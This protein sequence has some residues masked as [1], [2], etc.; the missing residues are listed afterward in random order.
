[1]KR[2]YIFTFFVLLSL[3]S[4]AQIVAPVN[5]NFSEIKEQK[6]SQFEL[7]FVSFEGSENILEYGS[8]PTYYYET[9]VPNEYF[10]CEIEINELFASK[11][12]EA[13][14]NLLSDNDLISDDYQ[15]IIKYSGLSAQ[16]YVLP[17]KWDSNH[18]QIIKLDSFELKID[19]V[20]QEKRHLNSNRTNNYTEES[21]LSSGTWIKMGIANSGVHRLSFTDLES[22]GVNPSQI[23]VNKIGIFGNYN[24]VLPE[25]NL[26]PSIDDLQE[27]S[28]FIS[29]IEDGKFD[30][31]DYILFYAQA[32]T[33]WTYNPFEGRFFHNNNIYSDTTYYFFTP[34]KG[35]AKSITD[36]DGLSLQPT[37]FVTT[38]IDYAVH[39]KESENLMSTGKEWYG[40]V[41]SSDTLEREFSFTFPNLVVDEPIYINFELVGRAFSNSFYDLIIDNTTVSDSNKIRFITTSLG[42]YARKS[43]NKTTFMANGDNLNFKLKYY[44]DD[45]N[46]LAWL[47]FIE[48]SAE[49]NLIFDNGQMIYR[50]LQTAASGNITQ[51]EI[52]TL[53]SNSLIWD[54][55]DIH[56][57]QN[58]SYSISENTIKYTIPTDSLKTFVVFDDSDYYSPISYKEIQNQNL[59]NINDVNFIIIR[60][61]MFEEEAEELANIHRN[62]D[63]LTT[64]CV[65]PEQIYNEFSS[66]S[67]DISAIRNFMRMLY[68][69]GAF[70]NQRAYLLLFGDASFDYKNRIHENTNIVPTYEALESLRATGSFVT[71]DYYGLLDINEGVSVSGDIDIGIGRFPISTK[72]EAISAVDK[73]S[74]YIHKDVDVMRDWRTN[75]C[76]IADDEDNNLHFNQAQGL[77]KIAD[78]LNSGIRISKVYLDAYQRTNIPG[79]HRYPDAAANISKQVEDGALIINYTGHG[80][81]LGWSEETVLDV[82][83]INGFDNINN[84][85]LIITATCE[86]SRFDDPE[87]T[88]AGEYFFLNKKGGAIGLLTTTRL[89]YAHANYIVNRRIYNN[90]LITENGD[91]PRLGDL[92]RLSKIPSNTNYLNFVLLGDPALTLAYPEHNIIT[93]TNIN[94]AVNVSDTIH[95]LSIVNVAGEI[96][97]S[98]N[99]IISNF[100]GYVYPKVIDKATI[101]T[102]LGNAGSSFPAEFKLFDRLLYDGKILVKNGKFEFEFAVPKDI[103][104][105][106]GFGKIQYYAIDTINFVDAWGGF[107]DMYIGGIDEDAIVNDIGP[108]IELYLNKTSFTSGDIVTNNPVL[109][110]YVSDDNGINSTGNG[111]GRNMVLVIDND[112]SNSIIV[113][114]YYSMDVNSY[115]SGKVVFPLNELSQGLHTLTLKVWDLQNNSSEK[116]IE[117]YIDDAIE[118]QLTEVL[119]YPNPVENE[120]TFKFA[121]N[122]SISDIEA[123]IRIYNILGDFV[124]ELNSNSIQEVNDYA[125]I[126]WDGKDYNGNT[127]SSG[128]YVYTLEVKDIY[129]NV[130]LQQQ[131]LYKINK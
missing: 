79:G 56:N 48:V 62:F 53:N 77:I 19:F 98:D 99:Q 107:D 121:H 97:N 100:N 123:T 45:L 74:K 87:F 80:G 129:G 35:S 58:I 102:T 71:D 81:V 34:D 29:G 90:L 66:G 64:I 86:F 7:Y 109:L 51:F 93:N 89:A 57:P 113:D 65:T 105:N 42:I 41:F 47:D 27:N 32:A 28:I 131:K 44:S 13:Q 39:E 82:P 54:I 46:A 94:N 30:I 103:V 63:G 119:N 88:S 43:T 117:F 55:T 38:F 11:F 91:T 31:G 4:V 126:S 84:L 67:Q 24:G 76:Y 116:T 60:P 12:T 118:I 5:L 21:V 75:I 8:F 125:T 16:I 122:K 20:P 22:M 23:D 110:S 3:A 14:S 124:V 114:S 108:D 73:I 92:V 68:D 127:I 33:T 17:F 115:K 120:T 52:E 25:S 26:R 72:E 1:M 15:Y 112:Y 37:Q 106:Y 2:F 85:P 9:K 10:G 69:K 59:H 95:A 61:Q 101:Y 104:Y 128:I 49:R 50:N 83:T 130:T 70:G 96:H 18:K 78:T 40:E 6:Y 111:L 36:I